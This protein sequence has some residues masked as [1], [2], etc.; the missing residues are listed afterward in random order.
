MS[1]LKS[2]IAFINALPKKVGTEIEPSYGNNERITY[3]WDSFITQEKADAMVALLQSEIN[4]NQDQ[5]DT[6]NGSTDI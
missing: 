3:T 4:V 5:I 6:Y 2:R 1:E